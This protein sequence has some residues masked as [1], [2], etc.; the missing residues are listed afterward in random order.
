MKRWSLAFCAAAALFAASPAQASYRVI[1]WSTG[2]CQIWDYNLPT[3]PWPGDYRI[4]TQPLPTFGAAV[5]A[6]ERLW[7]RGQCLI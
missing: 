5:R 2:I 4:M 7:R 6:K 3:R 1:K